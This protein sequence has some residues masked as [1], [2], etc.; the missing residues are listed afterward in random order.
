MG[1]KLWG[2]TGNEGVWGVPEAKDPIL[3]HP[4]DSPRNA[5]IVLVVVSAKE[6]AHAKV[7]N[8]KFHDFRCHL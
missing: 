5:S 8:E 3:L 1:Q 4:Q 7:V 6:V 2:L